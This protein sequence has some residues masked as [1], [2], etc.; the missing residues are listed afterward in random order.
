LFVVMAGGCAVARVVMQAHFWS[1]V[2]LGSV[3]GWTVGWWVAVLLDRV[4]PAA[5]ARATTT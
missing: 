5:G 2:I 1:D 4:M 3:L